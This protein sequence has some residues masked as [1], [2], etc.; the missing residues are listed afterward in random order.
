M[1]DLRKE[2][3]TRPGLAENIRK[4]LAVPILSDEA[5]FDLAVE[6]HQPLAQAYAEYS[7]Y[8]LDDKDNLPRIARFYKLQRQRKALLAGDEFTNSDLRADFFHFV[9]GFL[10]NYAEG[11]GANADALAEAEAQLKDKTVTDFAE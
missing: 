1:K 7:E 4:G 10:Y 6:G 5:V 11:R 8:V 9:K 2:S 3:Q